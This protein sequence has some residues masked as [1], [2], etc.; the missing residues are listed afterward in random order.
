MLII[1]KAV[2]DIE[3]SQLISREGYEYFGPLNLACSSGGKTAQV[4]EALQASQAKMT[5]TFNADYSA[6]FSQNQAILGQQAAKF[7]AISA[8]PMGYSPQQLHAATTSINE[9]TA[10]SAKAALGQAAA[11]ASKFGG[12]AD[13]SGGGAAAM[14]A[15]IASRAALT[16]SS[17]L[18]QLSQQNESMK[19]ENRW[20]GLQGLSEVGHEFG[21]AASGAQSGAGN[22]A[23]S[24]VSAGTGALEA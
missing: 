20:K 17:E 12:S 1:T 6:S 4:D 23:T 9:Q 5:D 19:M 13:I 8:N 15:D 24:A 11:F 14:G 16:K 22:A 7:A 21:S 2:Y 10:Q 3:T 18:S